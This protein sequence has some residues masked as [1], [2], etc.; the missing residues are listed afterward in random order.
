MSGNFSTG[1]LEDKGDRREKEGQSCNQGVSIR[2]N[3]LGS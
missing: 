3:G 1:F 2:D